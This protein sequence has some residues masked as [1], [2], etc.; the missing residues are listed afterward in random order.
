MLPP[1]PAMS[2]HP[3]KWLELLQIGMYWAAHLGINAVSGL[4]SQWA[5]APGCKLHWYD[6]F[7]APLGSDPTPLILIHGMFTTG[8][9]M[10][11]L[12]AILQSSRR[13]LVVDLPG[14]DYSFSHST[15]LAEAGGKEPRK[16]AR[17]C[18]LGKCIKAVSWLIEHIAPRDSGRQ[19]DL[20][21]H[22]FG[23][24]IV[25]QLARKQPGG[26]IRHAHLLAPGGANA[27]TLSSMSSPPDLD[28]IP[29]MIRPY[30]IPVLLG[31]FASPNTL[32]LWFDEGEDSYIE[33]A[34]L[35]HTAEPLY[36]MPCHLIFGSAD[37]LVTPR[38]ARGLAYS[39][40]HIET[41]VT[42]LTNAM[43]QLNVISPEAVAR[44]VE[45]YASRH[46]GV[47][48][49]PAAG[50][51]EVTKPLTWS[52]MGMRLLRRGLATLDWM[53]GVAITRIDL[54]EGEGG[55]RCASPAKR[56]AAPPSL[57]RRRSVYGN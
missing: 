50:A 7:E 46:G 51:N 22:S 57:R 16:Q 32:N 23:A 4:A 34:R 41:E 13:V 28:L 30:I 40:P 26:G 3:P 24:N 36:H 20:L 33:H 27:N 39:F 10:A 12:A 15:P 38:P 43:H 56:M 35:K 8:A 17:P 14:F 44:C 6:S 42:M 45:D 53:M 48:G 5:D 31:I 49:G 1:L 47:G 19:V 29:E 21:G 2:L 11:P 52:V 55:G 9:S 37:A 25:L 54:R 18:S